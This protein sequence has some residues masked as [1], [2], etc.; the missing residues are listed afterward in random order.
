MSK[1]SIVDCF[2]GPWWYSVELI[3]VQCL[4]AD[5]PNRQAKVTGILAAF[6]LAALAGCDLKPTTSDVHVLGPLGQ[7]TFPKNYKDLTACVIHEIGG[8]YPFSTSYDN[9]NSTATLSKEVYFSSGQRLV[10]WALTIKQIDASHSHAE[11][12][13][14][15]TNER[16][17]APPDLWAMVE[18]CGK[19]G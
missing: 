16:D 17:F 4:G 12:V 6:A 11:V 19:A 15:S 10:A 2:C 13:E 14:L 5:I 3:P 1:K 8:K 9:E 7:A 18:A